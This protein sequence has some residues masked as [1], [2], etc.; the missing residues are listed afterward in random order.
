MDKGLINGML[1][2]DLK[3]AFD[4]VDNEILL[5]KLECYGV[6]GTALQ[7]FQSYLNQRKQICKL[8]NIVLD[9]K[10]IC[11]GVPQGSNL[12]P[13]LFLIYINDT[14]ICIQTTKV[15][16][17]ADDTNMSCEGQSSTDIEYKLN[18]E[19]DIVHK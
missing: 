2:L 3:R 17:F 19:L 9:V 13:L 16:M 8:N 14:P 1:F 11:C 5:S 12:G 7:W 4:T 15:S 10:E 18:G 6:H